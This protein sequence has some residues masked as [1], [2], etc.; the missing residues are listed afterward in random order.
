MDK[1]KLME[2]LN[3]PSTPFNDG[4][5]VNLWSLR[6]FIVDFGGCFRVLF[7]LSRSKLQLILILVLML[8]VRLLLL[9]KIMMMMMTGADSATTDAGDL[10]N[11]IILMVM[12]LLMLLLLLF[13][14]RFNC[15]SLQLISV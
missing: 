8:L 1:I 9:I 11:N 13:H 5:M 3:H 10:N 7:I 2:H 14:H 12:I 6:D 4:K 15:L